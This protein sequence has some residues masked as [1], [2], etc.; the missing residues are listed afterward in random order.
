MRT[1]ILCL[2]PALALAQGTPPGL[3]V[4]GEGSV[5]RE[6]AFARVSFRISGQGEEA[7]DAIVKCR[8]KLDKMLAALKE[9]GTADGDVTV[10]PPSIATGQGDAQAAMQAMMRGRGGEEASPM[11]TV[12]IGI[13]VRVPWTAGAAPLTELEKVA[14]VLDKIT[15]AG[16][17]NGVANAREMYA[18]YGVSVEGLGPASPQVVFFAEDEAALR[19]EAYGKAVDDARARA[20]ALAAKLGRKLGGVLRASVSE[21]APA[22][23]SGNDAAAYLRLIYGAQRGGAMGPGT[24]TPVVRRAVQVQV[25]FALEP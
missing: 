19:A 23:A 21:G 17:D 22:D 20:E 5:S 9:G 24:P 15:E 3:T 25:E 12:A 6:P 4:T 8:E 13:D 14:T 10:N 1:F 18:M 16:A 7:K 11:V 2:I